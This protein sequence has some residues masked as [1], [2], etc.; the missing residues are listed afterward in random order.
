MNQLWA[1]DNQFCK[2]D[3]KATVA[4]SEHSTAPNSNTVDYPDKGPMFKEVLPI[5]N[6]HPFGNSS[7]AQYPFPQ[8]LHS[9]GVS[10][11]T[12]SVMLCA[13]CNLDE[14]TIDYPD[15]LIKFG[16][17]HSEETIY[18]FIQAMHSDK[19]TMTP[20]CAGE[21]YWQQSAFKLS[22]YKKSKNI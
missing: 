2:Q 9:S 10:P 22:I 20:I 18:S 7:G 19:D 15:L 3:C 11:A 8:C 1:S 6:T 12:P 16:V 13:R 4:G 5:N 17:C 21:L 14:I